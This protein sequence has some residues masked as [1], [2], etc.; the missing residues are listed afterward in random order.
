[1]TRTCVAVDIGNS[2]FHFGLIHHGM[3]NAFELP[4]EVP[5]KV[6]NFQYSFPLA[7]TEQLKVF[8][9]ELA[10]DDSLDWLIMSVHPLAEKL[11]RATIVQLFPGSQVH[12]LQHQQIPIVNDLICENKTGIDRLLAGWAAAS[13]YQTPT[14]IVDAGSAV[15]V[16]WVDR[17]M[18]F[19]GGMIFPGA[20]LA[21]KSL[22]KNTD[23]LPVVSLDDPLAIV[24]EIFGRETQGAIRSGIYWSQWGGICHSIKRLQS[25]GN[26]QC[27]VVLTGGGMQ[28]FETLLPKDW[29]Y[30][31]DLNLK[32]LLHLSKEIIPT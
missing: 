5:K 4:N 19:R 24:E 32:G 21:A 2:N 13:I 25:L 1:M 30:D 17:Q 20:R 14:I 26:N 6:E 12:Q 15:T 22:V 29:R 7:F 3:L 9:Q 11:L 27:T 8:C 16:D 10:C 23:A 28:A 31:P 18:V